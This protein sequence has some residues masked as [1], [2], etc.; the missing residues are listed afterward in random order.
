MRPVRDESVLGVAEVVPRPPGRTE[1]RRPGRRVMAEVER[2]HANGA[3]LGSRRDWAHPD[4][5]EGRP[6]AAWVSASVR[7]TCARRWI[8]RSISSG[9]EGTRR[10]MPRTSRW[11]RDF[12]PLAVRGKCAS[13]STRRGRLAK[14]AGQ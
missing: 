5:V 4:S 10:A 6:T 3:G 2:Q 11:T 8:W 9:P 13:M 1:A 12:L 7:R 14:A